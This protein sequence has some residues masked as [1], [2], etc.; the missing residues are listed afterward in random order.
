MI[1]YFAIFLL[2][3]AIIVCANF[4]YYLIKGRR[5]S[6]LFFFHLAEVLTIIAGPALFLIFADLN[7]INDCC[8]D[9]AF[10][11]PDNRIGIYA[12]IILCITVY[13]YSA[14]R[15]SISSPFLEVIINSLL[16]VGVIV[17]VLIC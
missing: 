10:F 13:F 9:S 11:A 15:K 16:V 2:I 17:N 8:T 4:F 1:F 3:S 7:E 5:L 6:N 14:Y 12:L